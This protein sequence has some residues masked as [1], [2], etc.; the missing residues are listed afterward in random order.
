MLTYCKQLYLWKCTVVVDNTKNKCWKCNLYL[1]M[2]QNCSCFDNFC[3]IN[4]SSIQGSYTVLNCEILGFQEDPE[5]VL[6]FKTLKKYWIWLK[7]TTLLKKYGNSKF[8]HLFIQILFFTADDSSAVMFCIVFH[9]QIFHKWSWMLLLKSFHLVLKKYEKW[10][11]KMCGNLVIC[12][13]WWKFFSFCSTLRA[14]DKTTKWFAA[15]H[16]VGKKP[17]LEKA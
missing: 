6:V 17:F 15:Y 8:N 4:V 12:L 13:Q 2:Y 1:L 7:C 11:L 14:L 3:L 9:E 10:F 16:T 5:K